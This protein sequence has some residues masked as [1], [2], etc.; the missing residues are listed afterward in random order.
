M[1]TNDVLLL[2]MGE[3]LTESVS[4]VDVGEDA[5]FLNDRLRGGMVAVGD[6]GGLLVVVVVQ[7]QESPCF[8]HS[9][10]RRRVN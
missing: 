6:K 8:F 7:V 4:F 1:P 9:T 3:I 5:L 10:T 2:N